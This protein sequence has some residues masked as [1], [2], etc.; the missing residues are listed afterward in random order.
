M[1][2][3][4][5]NLS[6]HVR[7]GLGHW[8]YSQ[9]FSERIV[10]SG[11]AGIA[12]VNARRSAMQIRAALAANPKNLIMGIVA[13][14]LLAGGVFLLNEAATVTTKLVAWAIAN[15]V[16]LLR[17]LQLS[18][19]FNRQPR[20]D[21]ETREWGLQI[22]RLAMLSG[23][24]WGMTSWLFLPTTTIHQ[25]AFIEIG[26]PMIVMGG[27]GAQASYRPLVSGF[28]LVVTAVF[29]AGL[30]RIA[31]RFHLLLALIEAVFPVCVL[32]F[33]RDQERT[34][35]AAID[36]GFEKE[37]LIR[38]LTIQHDTTKRAH[39]EAEKALQVAEKAD[40]AKT[41]F[42]ASATH[43]L[44]QPM[45][46]IGL[47]VGLVRERAL[48]QDVSSVFESIYELVQRMERLFI[49]LL[50]LSKFD[51]GAVRVNLSNVVLD[52]V[53]EEIE[54]SESPIA[55]SKNLM[56]RV[57]RCSLCVRSDPA[58]LN[59]MLRNLVE[60]AIRYTERGR[61]VVGVRRG[62][63]TIRLQVLDTG[64]GIAR[65]D[66]ERIFEEFVRCDAGL[67]SGKHGLGLGLSIVQR[68]AQL[69]GHRL[70]VRSE[71]GRGSCFEI[72]MPRAETGS[73]RAGFEEP[74]TSDHEAASLGGAFI[75][76]LEDE[77][78]SREAMALQLRQWGCHVAAAGSIS[79]L[80]QE[81][82]DHLRAP[83][84]M[85]SDYRIDG[86]PVGLQAVAELR[87]TLNASL[88][89]MIVT[90]EAAAEDLALLR[91]SGLPILFKPVA[92]ADLRFNLLAL[93]AASAS[94][95][96]ADSNCDMS[97]RAASLPTC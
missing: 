56:L 71:L 32:M 68:S 83:D 69:L 18:V 89:A 8:L 22:T 7:R 10:G 6:P 12:A 31:D 55:A 65:K 87:A 11:E 64:L 59:R 44:R 29:C 53:L 5:P 21:D 13:T 42:L 25:E 20:P 60:N 15:I 51:A 19:R 33:A 67:R 90:G 95:G 91:E 34:V 17:I 41:R 80:L 16:L 43:D 26:I 2:P 3:T 77:P 52:D 30:A 4:Y 93:L 39:Q 57:H 27:A 61:V 46:A 9:I 86:M 72:E 1:R 73:A 84:A 23:A 82:T 88:P 75:A 70:S 96:A 54:L 14:I 49:A 48:D 47:L 81:L 62:H 40:R 63:G 45:H 78:E 97:G 85:I 94:C 37:A 92:P 79:G 66:Q 36:L 35:R 74:P 38:D 50:D 28:V 58:L 24:L 76:L